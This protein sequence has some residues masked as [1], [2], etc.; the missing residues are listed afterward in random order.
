MFSRARRRTL[1]FG[2][3]TV[4][5][6]R[7]KGYFI[8]MRTAPAALKAAPRPFA[9]LRPRFESARPTLE[10]FL[11]DIDSHASALALLNGPPPEPRFDQIWCPRL[12]AAALY[13]LVRRVGPARIVE[14]G[15]GHST[16]FL[17]RAVRDAGLATRLTAIDPEP[18]ADLG[19]LDITLMR[20][21][22]QEADLSPLLAL[23]PG[24]ILF[25]D[26]SHVM[27]PGTDVDIILNQV[28][29]ALPAGV[30]VGF[31]DIFLPGP[32]PDAWPFSAY[33]EQNALAPLLQGRAELVWSSA[34]VREAMGDK[35]DASWIGR[36]P[37]KD[38]ARESL[39]LLR[40]V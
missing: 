27:M 36:Q 13:T 3:Q 39:L 8:P 19:G 7:A 26:S 16:R 6:L 17:W 4:L 21:V 28:L 25:V 10:A 24:D 22:L 31:H 34:F 30:L 5:G 33:N 23:A 32:Y 15:S 18:R 29:P 40:L 35:V 9:A 11:G 20:T 12:D 14:V 38:G 2:L 1:S 37:L